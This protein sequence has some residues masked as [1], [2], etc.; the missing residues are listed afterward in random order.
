MSLQASFLKVG[1]PNVIVEP[2]TKAEEGD[3]LIV[4][5]YESAHMG[6]RARLRFG[7]PVRAATESNLI[8]EDICPLKLEEDEVAFEFKPFEIK[9]LRAGPS[10]HPCSLLLPGGR[11]HRQSGSSRC[12]L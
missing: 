5:L 10:R 7:F 11:D 12:G 9:T 4:R 6:T 8:E 2:V 1:A 3:D